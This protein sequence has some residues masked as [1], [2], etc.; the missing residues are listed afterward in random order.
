LQCERQQ[1]QGVVLWRIVH[2]RIDKAGI[3]RDAVAVGRLLDHTFETEHWDCAQVVAARVEVLEAAMALQ[4]REAVGADREGELPSACCRCEGGAQIVG[5]GLPAVALCPRH[6]LCLIDANEDRRAVAAG[7]C[8][9]AVP[10]GFKSRLKRRGA[11]VRQF[12]VLTLGLGPSIKQAVADDA[13][14]F[15]PAEIG[16]APRQRFGEIEQWIGARPECA[17]RQPCRRLAAEARDD[18]GL[19][20]RRFAGAGRAE[21]YEGSQVAFGPHFA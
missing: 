5:E 19:Q 10:L 7:R 17:Q 8:P 2:Q 21:D 20:E 16:S 14:R 6:F 9:H 18:A 3:D 12:R 1:R 15:E 4:F 13:V 11:G